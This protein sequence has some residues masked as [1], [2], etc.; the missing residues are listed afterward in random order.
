MTCAT[1]V[2]RE[3]FDFQE[4]DGF[5]LRDKEFARK[6][7]ARSAQSSFQGGLMERVARREGSQRV[8]RVG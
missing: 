6:F 4:G 8:G 1:R 5:E 7:Q 2:T 3:T